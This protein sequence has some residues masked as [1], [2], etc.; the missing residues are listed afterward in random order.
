M[1]NKNSLIV[2]LIF[3]AV[4]DVF[5]WQKIIFG[6]SGD[7]SEIY[8]LDV[9][10][11]D[12]QLVVLPGN[13]KILIDGG[14]NNKVVKEL[15]Y[16]LG[17]TERYI[18][19]VVMSHPQYDHFAGLID[20]LNRYKAG[21]FI[22]NGRE[23]E[24]L[25]FRD[26]KDVLS[27]RGVPLIALVGGDKIRYQNSK[28]EII[29]PSE[30]LL[31]S[32]ELNDTS[33]VMKLESNGLKALFTGDIGIKVENYLLKNFDIDADVLKVAHHG[34]KFSSS[35]LFLEEATPEISVIEVGK[36]N[37]G[38]PTEKALSNLLAVGS[39]IFRTDVDGTVK[40]SVSDGEILIFKK[41]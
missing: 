23:G 34:S 41:K 26:L 27:E 35:E 20:V 32:K 10:Q 38:H 3:L 13:V 33:L 19:L 31:K 21:I 15:D 5:V 8:F 18:D 39:K 7:K 4:F 25:A 14:P 16:I 29:S 36:N 37:Y 12:S 24:I 9:G 28:L 22:Y 11:G 30:E 17:S 1:F 2:F 40:L 6:K